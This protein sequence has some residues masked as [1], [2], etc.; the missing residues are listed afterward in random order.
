MR[1]CQACQDAAKFA[2]VIMALAFEMPAPNTFTPRFMERA[3]AYKAHALRCTHQ[4]AAA[5]TDPWGRD[6]SGDGSCDCAEKYG[7]PGVLF[8]AGHLLD[9]PW[10]DG[11]LTDPA[12]A[13]R[14]E[15]VADGR[16][17]AG[18]GYYQ[19][20]LLGHLADA[21]EA[22]QREIEALTRANRAERQEM[23]DVV[24]LTMRNGTWAP[25]EC[26]ASVRALLAEIEALRADKARLDWMIA[27]A[28][29]IG[30]FGSFMPRAAIDAAMSKQ[31]E[32][33]E[34]P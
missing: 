28:V 29:D 8:E 20:P 23:S 1:A 30:W 15:L 33:E 5:P 16:R 18:Y 21:L 27:R 9:C 3:T 22:A 24:A 31:S 10:L 19:A 2:D 12:R 34:K 4:P 26:V 6:K 13:E 17:H 14:E 32:L 7:E 11:V 25:G